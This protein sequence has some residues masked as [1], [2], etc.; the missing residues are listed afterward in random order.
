MQRKLSVTLA[1][2][3]T[4]EKKVQKYEIVAQE[5][6]GRSPRSQC[7]LVT[8]GGPGG[9]AREAG[10][11]EKSRLRMGIFLV[12]S[13]RPTEALRG[14][15]RSRGCELEAT[16]TS[17]DGN[18]EFIVGGHIHIHIPIPVVIKFYRFRPCQLR[19][20]YIFSCPV[21]HVVNL[22]PRL[23]HPVVVSTQ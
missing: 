3:E 16:G 18:G 20:G 15:R 5:G 1:R 10:P 8:H 7:G 14:Q 23:P 22:S 9:R 6:G 19:R 2:Q 13:A 21:S 17:R 11:R 4:G 12:A